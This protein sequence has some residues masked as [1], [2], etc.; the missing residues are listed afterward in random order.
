MD[1]TDEKLTDN[2]NQPGAKANSYQ[3]KELYRLMIDSV[4][5]YA[6][7]MLDTKGNIVTWNEGAQRI[8]GYT[9]DEI[10][11]K[12]FSTFY[13]QEALDNEY[14]Q[15]ELVRAK[16]DGR[17]EDEGWRVKKD[18]SMIWANVII[19]ALFNASGKHVGFAKVTRDL[20]ERRKNEDLMLKNRD[21]LRI[22]T[23]L[24]NFIYTASHDLKAPI[25]NLEGLIDLLR[26]E[27]GADQHTDIVTR[28]SSSVTRLK[29]VI[30]DLTDVARLQDGSAPKEPVVIQ[31]LYEEIVENL[32]E[33]IRKSNATIV[34]DL[35][36]F[37]LRSYPRKNL[38][39]ILYN[40][41]SN[42]LKYADP[43]RA[44]YISVVAK[45]LN[46]GTLQ[47]SVADNGLGLNELQRQKVFTMYKRMHT[48]VEGSGLG[49]YIVK[50]I[51]ENNGDR[52][53]VESE[54]GKGSTF[55]LFF[56]L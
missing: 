47:L 7:F 8:K 31:E 24:D 35:G 32:N 52:I 15:F 45:L 50:R 48:H 29:N 39:S 5:D 56:S 25:T 10:I 23:D 18:G 4:K 33:T 9:T 41:I 6:I 55:K 20:S 44:P 43:N 17:F 40:L 54:V 27:L 13:T 1:K 34:A 42:A 3:N 49:L 36:S 28:I 38:R 14:P 53:E 19:T 16:I 12:H 30:D 11:G 37:T 51:L 2:K 22:N 26:E 46:E 21:L